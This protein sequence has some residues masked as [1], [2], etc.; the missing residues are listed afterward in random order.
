MKNEIKV[1]LSDEQLKQLSNYAEIRGCST[2]DMA[3]DIVAV[4]LANISAPIVNL[5]RQTENSSSN[6]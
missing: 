4:F 3:S 5:P 6:E 2:E 1:R